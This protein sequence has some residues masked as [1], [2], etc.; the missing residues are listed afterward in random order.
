MSARPKRVQIAFEQGIQGVW[1]LFRDVGICTAFG[2]VCLDKRKIRGLAVN[3][4]KN[5]F[6]MLSQTGESPK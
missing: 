6:G 1:A 4:L 2:Q 3:A 5:S